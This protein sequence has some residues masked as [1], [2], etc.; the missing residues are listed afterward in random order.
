MHFHGMMRKA[1]SGEQT[2]SLVDSYRLMLRLLA[3][4]RPYRILLSVT[5]LSMFLYAATEVVNPWLIKEAVDSV[6]TSRDTSDLTLAAVLLV[7]N[8][9]VG[10]GAN[11]VHL[12]TLSRVGQNLL[13]RLRT[14]TFNHMQR[15]SISYFDRTE[16]G[17]NMSRVQNDVQ[18]LQEFLSIFTLALGD[19]LRLAGF[20]I[21]MLLLKWEL[22]LITLT[23]IP[24]LFAI[25]IL[26]QR[27]A[28]RFFMRVRRA[29]A[30]VNAGLQEN[31]SGVRVIQSL[32]RQEKNLQSFDR[33]SQGYLEASLRASRLSSALNPSVE[34]LTAASTS[35]VIVFGGMMV[36]RDD[37]AVGV[38]V[39]FAL[40][41]Q[42]LFDPIRSLTMQYGQL[43]RAMTS[44]QHIFEMLD[45]K[46]EVDDKPGAVQL[47]IAQGD[48]IFENAS[49]SYTP[50]VPVLKNIN[51][52][53][54]PGEKIALVGPTGAGKTT[55][56]SLL[57]RLYDV[58]EGSVRI[59]G[60]DLRDVTRE[61][62]FHTKTLVD[63]LTDRVNADSSSLS[64]TNVAV[65]G[66][67]LV[68]QI[69]PEGGSLVGLRKQISVVPQEPFLFSGTIKD[70]IR[71][72][73]PDI[74]DQE[75]IEA[76][77]VVGAHDFII[78]MEKGYDTGV[79]E[80]GVNFSPGQ[81]QLMSLAR[82]LVSDPRIVILDEA[83]ATVDS[84]TEL[85][86]QRAL[87]VVLE[88]RTALIIAHR[89]STVRSVDRIVVVD[90]GRI[91][92]E[93][94]HQELLAKNGLYARLYAL[95]QERE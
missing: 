21:A 82:A 25:M 8:A 95:N 55:M 36:L 60:H 68:G 65:G 5:V 28:W 22:A 59:D 41:I 45:M 73:R 16:V 6:I 9:T 18:Q 88:G 78:Q 61:S 93:G 24:L 47:P 23:V 67:P 57:S 48:V 27:Y 35:L 92:E 76:A 32:N 87:K 52:H 56:V 80:R 81:R 94:T 84:R 33:T 2:L 31:I 90:Q 15:L 51:L 44:G 64:Q 83:T 91:V 72:S 11:Y 42:R 38:L 70:N 58:T 13:L 54:K 62:L 4:V 1:E 29:I 19:V 69:D 20:V 75:I 7:V 89:L 40:Y 66:G 14:S 85:F 86:L 37:L 46:P 10:Y 49:F 17:A 43:Q 50:E 74:T 71:Y 53:I 63:T 39:A 26:W 30:E 34:V 12:I 3:Y 79:E 77:K